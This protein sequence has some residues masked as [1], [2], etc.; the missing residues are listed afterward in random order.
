MLTVE[1][2]KKFDWANIPLSACIEGNALDSHFTLKLFHLLKEKITG[3]RKLLVEKVICPAAARIA[4]IEYQGCDVSRKEL[5]SLE[6]SLKNIMNEIEDNIYSKKY[7]KKTDN[8]NSPADVSDIL[9]LREEGLTLYP[10]DKTEKGQ[11]SADA[12]TLKLLLDQINKE[13]QNRGKVG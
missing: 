6:K 4:E 8:L 2:N 1:N 10:P 3:N 12:A 11:P 9:Y 7:V 5:D 13:L